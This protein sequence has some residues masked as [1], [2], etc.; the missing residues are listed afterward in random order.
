MTFALDPAIALLL[1]LALALLLGWAASHKWR[2][3]RSFAA[4]IETILGERP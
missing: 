1:R 4:A 2:D 3:V